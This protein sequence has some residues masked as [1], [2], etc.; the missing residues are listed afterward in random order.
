MNK[1]ELR[2]VKG[3]YEA[4]VAFF[5]NGDTTQVPSITRFLVSATNRKKAR[6]ILQS[7]F[8]EREGRWEI[9]GEIYPVQ[10]L[11]LRGS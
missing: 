1:P 10:A 8:S 7:Y 6:E 11:M 4:T 5:Y 3:I 9:Q 2:P